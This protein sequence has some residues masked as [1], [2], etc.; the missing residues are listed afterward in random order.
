MAHF[1]GQKFQK[2][3]SWEFFWAWFLFLYI[4]ITHDLKMAEWFIFRNKNFKKLVAMFYFCYVFFSF[5]FF[6]FFKYMQIIYDWMIGDV[7][8]VHFLG[9]KQKTKTKNR[10][11][12]IVSVD[13]FPTETTE[14]LVLGSTFWG[15]SYTKTSE[16]NISQ[17]TS[18]FTL[19]PNFNHTLFQGPCLEK[20]GNSGTWFPGNFD[21]WR[22]FVPV[23]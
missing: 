16:Q 2:S 17:N 21:I 14:F 10:K 7:K 11:V 9:Q 13:K 8:M 5:L 23:I 15:T 20:I 18:H 22:E 1:Y 3:N 6:F 19:F 12:L 4:N